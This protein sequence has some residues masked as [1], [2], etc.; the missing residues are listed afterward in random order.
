MDAR[1][2]R[3]KLGYFVK[4]TEPKAFCEVHTL[5]EYDL[6]CGGIATVFT[7]SN[8]IEMVGMITIEREFPISI[9]VSDAQYVYL[10]LPSGILPSLD[11]TKPFFYSIVT[12][13]KY[14]GTSAVKMPFNRLSTA[15]FSYSDLVFVRNLLKNQN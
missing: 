12:N 15:H 14:Q 10:E 1:G 9:V 13:K 4:G 11:N 2:S 7:P 8:H 3:I 6:V 5:V